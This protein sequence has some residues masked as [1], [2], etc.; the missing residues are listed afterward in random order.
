[1][2]KVK[3]TLIKIGNNGPKKSTATVLIKETNQKFRVNIEWID[4]EGWKPALVE[5]VN[6][7]KNKKSP[8]FEGF[9]I[10]Y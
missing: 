10:L 9:F 8:N 7:Y 5:E 1:M 6:N 4:G 2:I 3:D